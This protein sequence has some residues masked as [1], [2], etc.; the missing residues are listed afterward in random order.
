MNCPNVAPARAAMVLTAPLLAGCE[1]P[2]PQVIYPEPAPL[3]TA[4][5]P[6]ARQIVPEP[7]PDFGEGLPDPANAA[8][9][10]AVAERSGEFNVR[11][12]G[13]EAVAAG[14]DR[15]GSGAIGQLDG[16]PEWPLGDGVARRADASVAAG[17]PGQPARA[18]GGAE[19]R[20]A[21]EA[22]PL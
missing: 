10:S 13:N 17:V 21:P 14:T 19:S 1:P 18:C 20:S 11:V 3:P 2:P 5:T 8:C 4:L 7:G 9:M 12:L 15:T 6:P 22:R 16:E